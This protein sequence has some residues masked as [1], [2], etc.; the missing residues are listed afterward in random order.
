MTLVFDQDYDGRE[1]DLEGPSS[2]EGVSA[3]LA[4]CT[5]VTLN[6]YASRK[7]WDLTGLEVTV[8]TAYEGPNPSLFKVRVSYPEQ[9]AENQIERLARIAARC[10]VHRLIAE[11]TPIEVLTA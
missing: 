4:S 9:L 1:T 8:E 11:A 5:A 7:G 6:I 2:T 3:A 10:P